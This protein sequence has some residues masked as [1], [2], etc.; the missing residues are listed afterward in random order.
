M[1]YHKPTRKQRRARTNREQLSV[2]RNVGDDPLRRARRLKSQFWLYVPVFIAVFIAGLYGIYR[3]A[4]G[5]SWLP[6]LATA[7]LSIVVMV[8]SA[9]MLFMLWWARRMPD[10]RLASHLQK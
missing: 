10:E 3:A 6:P 4:F 8:G 9:V 5:E 1:P 2:Q 7:G